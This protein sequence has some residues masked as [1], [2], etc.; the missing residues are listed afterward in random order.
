MP[1]SGLFFVD[2]VISFYNMFSHLE[3]VG[4]YQRTQHTSLKKINGVFFYVQSS[5]CELVLYQC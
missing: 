2:V 3:L 5:M 1:C 4:I